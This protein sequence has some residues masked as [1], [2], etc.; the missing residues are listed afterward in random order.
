MNH[1]NVTKAPDPGDMQP[2]CRCPPDVTHLLRVKTK[3][4]ALLEPLRRAIDCSVPSL[5]GSPAAPP[6][7]KG[8]TPLAL[9]PL[10]PILRDQACFEPA[11]TEEQRN[12]PPITIES[13]QTLKKIMLE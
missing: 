6:P 7:E 8:H 12:K 11:R 13:K 3:G 5:E 10:P 1:L 2:E 9:D 4:V